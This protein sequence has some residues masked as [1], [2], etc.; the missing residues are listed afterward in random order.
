MFRRSGLEYFC[1]V[2]P[3]FCASGEYG[4]IPVSPF[5]NCSSRSRSLGIRSSVQNNRSLLL[6]RENTLFLF[7]PGNRKIYRTL[8]M[9][10]RGGFRTAKIN[11]NRLAFTKKPCRRGQDSTRTVPPGSTFGQNRDIRETRL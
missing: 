9:A 5:S 2:Q 7:Q 6:C 3:G 8:D 10:L 4:D 11:D 1:A